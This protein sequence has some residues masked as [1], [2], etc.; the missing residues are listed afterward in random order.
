MA[1]SKDE[2]KASKQ[3]RKE[4]EKIRS[5]P[6]VSLSKT[7]KDFIVLL[8]P[9]KKENERRLRDVLHFNNIWEIQNLHN[10]LKVNVSYGHDLANPTRI[11]AVCDSQD[12]KLRLLNGVNRRRDKDVPLSYRDLIR[13]SYDQLSEYGE[14]ISLE[15][16]AKSVRLHSRSK[17]KIQ[18]AFKHNQANLD[19]FVFS[20]T[21][22]SWLQLSESL[23]PRED[24]RLIWEQVLKEFDA[25]NVLS[26]E[27]FVNWLN[28][29]MRDERLNEILS[30]PFVNDSE[31]KAQKSGVPQILG[32]I[33]KMCQFEISTYE[34][35][36]YQTFKAYLEWET[37]VRP[38]EWTQVQ[39]EDMDKPLSHYW[40]ASSHNTYLTGRQLGGESTVEVYRQVLLAG[41]RCIELDCWDGKNT[42]KGEPIITHGNAF[43]TEVM[44]VDVIKAI[45]ETAFIA[46]DYP[47]ILS[48]ENH[49][50]KP[51]QLKMA[52][53]CAEIFGDSLLDKPLDSYPLEPGVKLPS[54]TQLK[55]R[56]IIKNKKLNSSEEMTMLDAYYAGQTDI[57]LADDHNEENTADYDQIKKIANNKKAES[58]TNSTENDIPGSTKE[59]YSNLQVKHT[60]STTKVHPLLSVKINYCTSV[61]FPGF[62]ESMDVNRCY[63]MSSFSETQGM[64]HLSST[65]QE[66]SLYNSRQLS[67]I[68]PKGQRID[69]SN[70]NP[71]VFWSAGCQLVALNYQSPDEYFQL[72]QGRFMSNGKCGYVLKPRFMVEEV[73]NSFDPF[74]EKFIHQVLAATYKITI[75]SG[76][77]L[78]THD[79]V[80]VTM[81]LYALPA[82]CVTKEFKTKKCKGPHPHWGFNQTFHLRKVIAPDLAILRIAV[83]EETSNK[84]LAQRSLA[85]EDLQCGYRHLPLASTANLPLRMSSLFIKVHASC[86]VK[87]EHSDFIDCLTNPT[88]VASRYQKRVKMLEHAG[89]DVD[90]VE[91][92][93]PNEP[94][95][96]SKK[97]SPFPLSQPGF[98]PVVESSKVLD[99]LIS[100][101]MSA[102]LIGFI[103]IEQDFCKDKLNSLFETQIKKYQ[104]FLKKQSEKMVKE[105][106]RTKKRIEKMK[107]AKVTD[108]EM[109]EFMSSREKIKNIIKKKHQEGVEELSKQFD[110]ERCLI[111][112]RH[113][114]KKYPDDEKR[115]QKIQKV[116]EAELRKEQHQVN[117]QETRKKLVENDV[118]GKKE[119]D[120]VLREVAANNA[121]KFAKNTLKLE[122]VHKDQTQF[123]TQLK[124][125][126]MNIFGEIR[127][128]EASRFR[129]AS[130][131]DEDTMTSILSQEHEDLINL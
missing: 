13:A 67:R 18:N 23:L 35:I 16:I 120:R 47:V 100:G 53:Y 113:L 62:R 102:E 76:L 82:D 71:T 74:S 31:V 84:V 112:R 9:A 22:E 94:N 110:R 131:M 118:K 123:F 28:E 26:M 91:N 103:P 36:D 7:N 125:D 73:K 8:W 104:N 48:F 46:S 19:Q 130:G 21:W 72:N 92:Q 43:C 6:T 99:S 38:D 121:E 127:K 80:Y 52:N 56:I 49:C 15:E 98:G 114:S 3:E 83:H 20:K 44:F 2:K 97:P 29:T 95:K 51:N 79:N 75:I 61:R 70:Y 42:N 50:S 93:N 105:E 41:C 107:K 65:S 54:P 10:G 27:D 111:L 14:D 40:V 77:W 45:A 33:A 96:S 55:G 119:K 78:G 90:G 101:K 57:V 59:I 128:I 106:A 34:S 109:A 12:E 88:S 17:S 116:H 63:Q 115:M 117:F 1:V 89:M 32:S 81:D 64:S 4:I 60:G 66:F 24:I 86:L 37:C 5:L 30:P 39:E 69:S 87:S 58:D 25:T 11:E 122:Q 126:D 85:I 108:A 68:Y 124:R 129:V